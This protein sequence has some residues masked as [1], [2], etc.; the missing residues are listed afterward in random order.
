MVQ[1]LAMALESRT[2]WTNCQTA[3]WG[4]SCALGTARGIA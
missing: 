1:R 3:R 4:Q 2:I